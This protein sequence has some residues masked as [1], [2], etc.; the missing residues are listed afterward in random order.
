[1]GKGTAVK[2]RTPVPQTEAAPEGP[3]CQH[4]WLIETPRGS[5]SEGRC[6]TCGEL[7]EFRNSANDYVWED[8]SGSGYNAW[9][10]VRTK[11][12]KADDDEVAASTG[13]ASEPALVV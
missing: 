4:H 3:V 8:E 9:R 6:K 1:M 7:R 11:P 13:S 5:M 2:E 12:A 10:G